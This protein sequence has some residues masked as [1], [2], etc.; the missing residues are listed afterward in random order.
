VVSHLWAASDFATPILMDAFYNALQKQ[1][2]EVPEAL[3]YA[4]NHLKTVT[5]G[6]LR[7]DGWLELPRDIDFPAEIREA[8]EEMN[9]L[10]DREM[11][12]QDEFYWGGFTVHKSR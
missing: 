7:R 3:Q 11:P 9:L 8:V 5:I 4:K 1:G 6:Q 12:F 10:P 2:Q